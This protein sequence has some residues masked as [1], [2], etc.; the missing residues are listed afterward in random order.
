MYA[1]SRVTA[2][3]ERL[4]METCVES[5]CTVETDGSWIGQR[6][7]TATVTDGNMASTSDSMLVSVWNT[8]SHDMTVTGATVS[9]SLV[10]SPLVAYNVTAADGAS[11]TQQQLGSN[12]G[13]YDSVVSFDMTTSNVF[14]PTDIGAETM[15]IDFD[16]DAATNWGLWYLRTADSQWTSVNHVTQSAGNN[17]G[18]TLTFNHDGGLEGNLNGG[19]Y[20]IFDVATAAAE[21]PAT[22]V[23]GLTATLQPSAQVVFDW[24]YVDD[25]LL[26]SADTV[27]L[28]HCSGDGCDP[29]AGT[30]MPAMNP[31]TT[32]WTLV[33]TDGESYTIHVQTENGNTD[34]ASGAALTGGGMAIT[35]TADGSVSPAPGIN[36]DVPSAE[37]DSLTFTWT[38]TDT[39]DVSSWMVCWAASQSVVQDSFDSVVGDGACAETTDTTTSL[40]VT[41]Q[42]MC[43]GSCSSNMFFAVGAKDATGNV[44]SP[45]GDSHL[46]TA[47]YS[48]GVVDPGVVD[49][50][51]N[52]P[53]GQ[54]DG[55]PTGAIAAIIV[56]VVIA[57]IGGAFILTRGTEGDGEGK[58]WDY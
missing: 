48:S 34:E 35:V 8:Y 6:M 55:M 13:A 50:G 28:Y 1:W 38:A 44:Y 53:A 57:V 15:T 4:D 23:N 22:G 43:G 18:V 14:N 42:D 7:I 11:Y 5:I 46:M 9:Y 20:A 16:G 29:M 36:A 30:A 33:G 10:Y 37:G 39:G 25:S 45:D 17:G 41:E 27:N 56:L 3:G 52:D 40:T 54:D 58:E 2:D 49:G 51:G 32:S 26:G 21:P 31:T 19:T 47:D 24:C 12:A